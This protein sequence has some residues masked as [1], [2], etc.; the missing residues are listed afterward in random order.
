MF[1]PV[2]SSTPREIA[3]LSLLALLIPFSAK[4]PRRLLALSKAESVPRNNGDRTFC[5]IWN[6]T[7]EMELPKVSLRVSGLSPVKSTLSPGAKLPHHENGEQ[8]RVSSAILSVPGMLAEI[9]SPPED[10]IA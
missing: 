9:P 10:V 6:P 7:P 1:A 8:D 5:C 4:K 3:E 2:V